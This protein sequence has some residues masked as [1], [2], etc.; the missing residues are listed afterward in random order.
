MKSQTPVLRALA[1]ETRREILR[2]LRAGPQTSGDIS[3]HFASSWPTISRHLAILRQAG[4]VVSRREGQQIYYELDTSVF[5]DLIEHLMEWMKPT[6][7][8]RGRRYQEV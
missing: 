1:D 7:A 2:M 4:L 3:A 8:R 6:A 5:Q